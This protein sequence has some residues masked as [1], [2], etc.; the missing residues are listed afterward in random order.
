VEQALKLSCGVMCPV[1]H[2]YYHHTSFIVSISTTTATIITTT[3]TTTA[4][5]IVITTII[6]AATITTPAAHRHISRRH[7]GTFAVTDTV[8]D[9][10]CRVL[11]LV[12][13][14]SMPLPL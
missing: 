11:R 10:S 1:N 12:P 5:T 2:Y 14:C 9:A 3:T 8:D 4:A 6:V 7:T 13:P